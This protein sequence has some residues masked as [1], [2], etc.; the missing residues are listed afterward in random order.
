M[1][2]KNR[3]HIIL[4]ASI[5]GIL[6]SV[7]TICVAILVVQ[8]SKSNEC[9]LWDAEP[10][11]S[12]F[13]R[14]Q[15]NYTSDDFKTIANFYGHLS[16]VEKLEPNAM[17]I[18]RKYLPLNLRRVRSFRTPDQNYRLIL[19]ADCGELELQLIRNEFDR[20][21]SVNYAIIFLQ[22]YEFCY[23]RPTIETKGR[24]HYRC[25]REDLHT[26]KL[27]DE[28][29]EKWSRATIVFHELE[30]EIDGDSEWIRRNGTFSTAA[31]DCM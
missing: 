12:A 28:Q 15:R 7:I 21:L 24:Q 9:P 2:D 20:R 26:C 31:S 19:E 4:G 14:S 3:R 1:M 5:L 27:F 10:A 18:T 6:L 17:A 25:Q 22:G 13:A 30:F 29:T 16:L 11:A 8:K 23:F